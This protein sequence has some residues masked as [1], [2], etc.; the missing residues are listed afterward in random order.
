MTDK[1]TK[2]A[3]GFVAAVFNS[4]LYYGCIELIDTNSEYSSDM[5]K[6]S[7]DARAECEEAAR[8]LGWDVAW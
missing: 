5:Y 6:T 8:L 4:G 3:T 2:P 1:P 7:G